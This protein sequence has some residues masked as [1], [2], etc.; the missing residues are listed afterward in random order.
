[1]AP[2]NPVESTLAGIWVDVL[3][4]DRVGLLDNFF[5]LGG[6]SLSATRAHSRINA[7]FHLE[8]PLNAIFRQPT[9]ADL[10][11]IIEEMIVHEIEGLTEDEA[12]RLAE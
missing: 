10:A 5:G 7:A 12:Q 4:I 9:V 6:D 3:G 11:L 1:M 2:R 8:L